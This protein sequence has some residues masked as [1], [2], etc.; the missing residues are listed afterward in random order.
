[1]QHAK[2]AISPV[3]RSAE[4]P[5]HR[6]T[7]SLFSRWNELDTV[8]LTTKVGEAKRNPALCPATI[9]I[10]R[11]IV[12]AIQNGKNPE[13]LRQLTNLP[14][15]DVDA[16][17]D[18]SPHKGK[19]LLVIAA[20][21]KNL[22]FCRRLLQKGANLNDIAEPEKLWGDVQKLMR[23]AKVIRDVGFEGKRH[24]RLEAAI[25][26]YDI[27]KMDEL[28]LQETGGAKGK[29]R[30]LSPGNVEQFWQTAKDKNRSDMKCAILALA[31]PD[32]FEPGLY[33]MRCNELKRSFQQESTSEVSS[34]SDENGGYAKLQGSILRL[35]LKNSASDRAHY[36]WGEALVRA[37]RMKDFASLQAMPPARLI[38]SEVL[39]QKIRQA[40][41]EALAAPFIGIGEGLL[42]ILLNKF[43]KTC[44]ERDADGNTLLHIAVDKENPPAA[45]FLIKGKYAGPNDTAKNGESPLYWSADKGSENTARVLG[46]NGANPNQRRKDLAAPIHAATLNDRLGMIAY[47]IDIGADVDARN[48]NGET[49]LFGAVQSGHREA[50]QLLYDKGADLYAQRSDGNTVMH[51]AVLAEKTEMTKFLLDLGFDIDA[52]GKEENPPL[53]DAIRENLDDIFGLLLGRGADLRKTSDIGATALHMACYWDAQSI[54]EKLIGAGLDVKAVDDNGESVFFWTAKGGDVDIAKVLLK[55]DPDLPLVRAGS[56]ET[57]LHVAVQNGEQSM[58]EFLLD[59]PK[60]DD[61]EKKLFDD[62][63][64]TGKDGGTPFLRAVESGDVAVARMLVGRGADFMI[65]DDNGVNAL[66]A[67]VRSGEFN[68]IKYLTDEL[69]MAVGEV[70]REG[71][72]ALHDCAARS[73]RPVMMALI[74]RASIDDVNRK[75][76]KGQ[77]PLSIAAEN[78]QWDAA[79][80]LISVG[81]GT[82]DE[83]SLQAI[84]LLHQA[85][86]RYP[87]A[88]EHVDK[89]IRDYPV[90]GHANPKYIMLKADLLIKHERFTEAEALLLTHSPADGDVALKWALMLSKG[91]R[92]AELLKH[93]PSLAEQTGRWELYD[94]LGNT[95]RA[96]GKHDEAIA[97]YLQAD[98][99]N[100]D[101]YGV[102]CNLALALEEF[103]NVGESRKW[104]AIALERNPEGGW[105]RNMAGKYY[106]YKEGDEPSTQLRAIEEKINTLPRSE[107]KVFHY[108]IGKMHHDFKNFDTALDHYLAGGALN[109]QLTKNVYSYPK[110]YEPMLRTLNRLPRQTLV[111]AIDRASMEGY[112]DPGPESTVPVLIVGAPRSG[113]SIL[114]QAIGNHSQIGGAGE[115]MF[116]HECVTNIEVKGVRLYPGK[117]TAARSPWERGEA[118]VHRLETQVGGPRRRILTKLPGD[119]FELIGAAIIVPDARFIWCRRHPLAILLSWLENMFH[120]KSYG[121]TN[122]MELAIEALVLHEKMRDLS[123]SVLSREK[124]T[125][126]FHDELVENPEAQLKRL[127]AHIDMPW[128]E[129]CL[130]PE[131]NEGPMATVSASQ[132]R[133]GINSKGVEKWRNYES[134]FMQ[135]IGDDPRVKSL[136]A[137][138]NKDLQK[139]RG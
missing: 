45:T 31:K 19:T 52:P 112:R 24:T 107:Q 86:G 102:A 33:D 25:S 73:N 18:T 128:E 109:M 67:A 120:S 13:F 130:H 50:A 106:K 70:D 46:E 115:V 27:R 15:F 36:A 23:A 41:E 95:C 72:S 16:V 39:K 94:L 87:V 29:G 22:D 8:G 65:T 89:L 133:E 53:F 121:F 90:E 1:M 79:E 35:S 55:Q 56:G 47:L 57:A 117:I 11:L 2:Q 62:I 82:E 132:V 92:N 74:E 99:R 64:V 58:V 28:L 81:A 75:N 59:L 76:N 68:M 88:M 108:A 78:K 69:D 61:P 118:Y 116:L 14:K 127:L 38:P 66:R 101:N 71:N 48:R 139:S 12:N 42:R 97:A 137:G 20:E 83:Q 43:P 85:R 105:A 21:N 10:H 37:V 6:R 125:E 114:H 3:I 103:G 110:G 34:S 49:A 60:P 122:D 80:L 131:S 44:W 113:T 98:D 126:V 123:F 26:E 124:L 5:S 63:N 77:T 17:N 51:A 134:A 104:L 4:G 91:S 129:S 84:A 93:L 40:C 135:R 9:E 111:E 54:A 136:I 138:Y 32:W 96:L 119:A 100:K 30:T 7:P